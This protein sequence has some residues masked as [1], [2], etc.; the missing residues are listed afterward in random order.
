MKE[1]MNTGRKERRKKGMDGWRGR[2]GGR[3]DKLITA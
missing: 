2:E 3:V 1:G